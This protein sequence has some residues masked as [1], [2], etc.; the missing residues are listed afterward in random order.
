MTSILHIQNILLL[1]HYLVKSNPAPAARCIM[2][3]WEDTIGWE[4]QTTFWKVILIVKPILFS[5]YRITI[6]GKK[7]KKSGFLMYLKL[8]L[9]SCSFQLHSAFFFLQRT[10]IQVGWLFSTHSATF[11]HLPIKSMYRFSSSLTSCTWKQ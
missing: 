10:N 3:L 5:S 1:F 4:E 2:L 11:L 7:K 6:A 8:S 9:F